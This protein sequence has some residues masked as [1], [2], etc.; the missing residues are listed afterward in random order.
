M[1]FKLTIVAL[2][3][4]SQQVQ[5]HFSFVR[6]AVNG[7]W[8]EPLRYIRNKTAPF[9]EPFTPNANYGTRY[10]LEPV[11]ASDLKE[12]VRCGRDNMAHAANTEVLTVRAGDTMEVAHSR[13][14]PHAWTD[15]QFN[16]CPEG[17]GTCDIRREDRFMTINHPGPVLVHLSK[18]PEGRNIHEYDGSG[19]WVKIM[20]LG[21]DMQPNNTEPVHWLAF[22]YEQKPDR[23]VFKIPAQT[24]EGDYLLRTDLI[25]PGFDWPEI[26]SSGIAQLYPS[27]AQI[28]VVS[29][30]T[31]ELPK[32]GIS[33]P[34]DFSHTSPGMATTLEM[35][36]NHVLDPDFVYPGGPLW[37]G[38]TLVQDKPV[39]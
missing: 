2:V 21:L 32:G 39:G 3:A 18:V 31:G 8:Q 19:E 13:Y 23:F 4:L 25:W 9:E 34:E 26:P 28:H 24:P 7:E 11:Y 36:R 38:E 6:L 30:A 27:C 33:I 35:Y 1:V 29:E 5:G 14:E 37:D 22:N 17:R 10:W 20:T 16:E 15:D 12:S